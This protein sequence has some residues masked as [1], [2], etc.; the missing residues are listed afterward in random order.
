MHGTAAHHIT[1][2][3]YIKQA[4]KVTACS[5]FVIYISVQIIPH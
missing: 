1:G 4:Y 2:Y 5:V 3:N